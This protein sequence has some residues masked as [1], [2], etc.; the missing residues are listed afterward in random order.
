MKLHEDKTVFQQAIRMTAEK[1]QIADIYVEK[2]YWICYALHLIYNSDVKDYVIFKGGTALSKCFDIIERFSEDIDL[3]LLKK[4]A[5]SSNQLK[6]KL[7]KVSKVLIAPFEEEEMEGITNKMGMIRKVA[8]NYPKI[9]KGDF[10]QVRD[11]LILE[12]SWLGSFEPYSMKQIATYIY[13]MMQDNNQQGL[14]EQYGMKPFDVLVLDVRRT[15]CEK[16]MSLVRFSHTETPIEDLNNK[17]RHIYDIHQLLQKSEVKAFF[18]SEDFE[19]MLI[20]VANDDKLSFRSKNEWLVMHPKEAIIFNNPETTWAQLEKVYRNDF[21]KLVYGELPK[22]DSILETL[23]IVSKR[24]QS[25]NWNLK[26]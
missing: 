19:D 18:V 21:G 6:T 25:I 5:E 22:E 1:M 26:L 2:D 23:M 8:Y 7:R 9:H 15:L 24:L 17:V 11:H 13:D 4:E 14:A 20:K 3:V 12:A 16:I 10:G